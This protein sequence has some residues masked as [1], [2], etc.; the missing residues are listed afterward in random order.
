MIHF[1]WTVL[2][3]VVLGLAFWTLF[4][5]AMHRFLFHWET[6]IPPARSS[7]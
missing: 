4:E 3:S 6:N 2:G 5:Y 1:G 7:T